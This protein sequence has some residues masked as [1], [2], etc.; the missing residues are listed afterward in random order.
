M[1]Y[2]CVATYE[3]VGK[4]FEFTSA[5]FYPVPTSN[6]FTLQVSPGFNK[7]SPGPELT[8]RLSVR[9]MQISTTCLPVSLA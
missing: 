9:S 7:C 5:A 1:N 3:S 4:A 2:S 6:F 8:L